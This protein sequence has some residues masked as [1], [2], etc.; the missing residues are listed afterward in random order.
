MK[1]FLKFIGVFGGILLLSA[2]LAPILYDFFQTFHPYKFERIFNR[3]VMIGTLVAA[4][5]FCPYQKR[6]PGK[7]WSDLGFLKFQASQIGR[8]SCRER[9][10]R[11]V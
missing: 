3:L 7:V 6:N 10:L 8:A 2:F 5:F 1:K 9:V 4:V 11:L